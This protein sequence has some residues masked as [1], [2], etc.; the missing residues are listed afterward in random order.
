MVKPTNVRMGLRRLGI[1]SSLACIVI[2]MV[3]SCSGDNDSGPTSG[4]VFSFGEIEWP[5]KYQQ[6]AGG[7]FSF[8]VPITLGTGETP[9]CW[10]SLQYRENVYNGWLP[11]DTGSQYIAYSSPPPYPFSAN[12]HNPPEGIYKLFVA[13]ET[14]QSELFH[15]GNAEELKVYNF[16]VGS[17]N[18]Y[19]D[20]DV[21]YVYQQGLDFLHAYE[22]PGSSNDDFHYVVEPFNNTRVVFTHTYTPLSPLTRQSIPDDEIHFLQYRHGNSSYWDP[23]VYTRPKYPYVLFAIDY[24]TNPQDGSRLT[25]AMG[26]S[27]SDDKIAMVASGNID[28]YFAEQYRAPLKQ[29]DAAHELA[30]LLHLTEYCTD[31]NHHKPN[32]VARVCL[33]TDMYAIQPQQLP[34][35]GCESHVVMPFDS[36]FYLCDSCTNRMKDLNFLFQGNVPK[37]YSAPAA[38]SIEK[39]N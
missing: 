18:Y 34:E 8:T 22:S 28:Q 39:E 7:S 31:Q 24:F 14:S 13:L 6:T 19:F 3:I 9:T 35:W 33:M 1:L 30:H 37:N 10:Y 29:A 20:V 11:L 12:Y 5:K 2:V 15:A 32:T 4:H 16:Y 38:L 26:R 17:S 36:T 21:E 25:E 23:G 27:Q